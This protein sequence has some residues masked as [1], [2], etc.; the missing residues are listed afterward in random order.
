MNFF[1]LGW[2]AAAATGTTLRGILC[3]A[4]PRRALVAVASCVARGPPWA[5]SGRARWR[6]PAVGGAMP[7]G[8]CLAVPH[9]MGSRGKGE[10]IVKNEN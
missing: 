4:C 5:S 8:D 7:E 2:H 3:G 10:V 6:Y 9:T 1:L